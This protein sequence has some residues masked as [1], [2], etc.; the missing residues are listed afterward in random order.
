MQELDDKHYQKLESIVEVICEKGCISVNE[1]IIKLKEGEYFSEIADL[2]ADE[3][4]IILYELV[5]IMK[6]YKS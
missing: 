2:T 3:R 6:V 4:Y 1:H 5:A